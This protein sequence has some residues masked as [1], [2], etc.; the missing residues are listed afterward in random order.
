MC[1]AIPATDAAWMNA[2][3]C[4]HLPPRPRRADSPLDPADP[5]PEGHARCRPRGP[6]RRRDPRA[7]PGG[8]A[9]PGPV[10]R[11]LHVPAR[12]AGVGQLEI[13]IG[14]L[15]AVGGSPLH[16]QA[17]REPRPQAD[18]FSVDPV[19]GMCSCTRRPLM[20]PP[21]TCESSGT[22]GH[23]RYSRIPETI[24]ARN[25]QDHVKPCHDPDVD[26]K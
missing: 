7:R 10:P 19:A 1:P 6:V 18:I 11:G 17:D 12:Q 16:A 23:K 25:H 21:Q 5:W 15:E 22:V 20:H 24:D 13:T 8:E 2:V 4:R 26:D 9:E 3:S 14:D